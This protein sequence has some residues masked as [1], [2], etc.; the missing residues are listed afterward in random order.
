MANDLINDL[1][2][3]YGEQQ[4]P[5]ISISLTRNVMTALK[6]YARCVEMPLATIARL[7]IGDFLSRNAVSYT[8]DKKTGKLAVKKIQLQDLNESIVLEDKDAQEIEY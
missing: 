5:R 2:K 7:A 8:V 6:A 3:I 1:T 4:S